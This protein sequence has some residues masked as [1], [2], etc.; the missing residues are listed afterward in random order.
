MRN[1]TQNAKLKHRMSKR[2]TKI[3]LDVKYVNVR[4]FLERMR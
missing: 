2:I 4:A 3:T 1:R